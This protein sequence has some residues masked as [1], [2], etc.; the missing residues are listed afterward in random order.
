MESTT[1]VDALIHKAAEFRMPAVG[2]T[3]RGNMMAAFHFVAAGA[4]HNKGI[5]G[6]IKALE[7]KLLSGKITESSENE[8]GET[9]EAERDLKDS[10]IDS[11]TF[12][13]EDLKTAN[14]FTDC[15]K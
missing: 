14:R 7:E 11:F 9:I 5:K 6:K 1:K 8:N 15:W 12:D 4:K 2:M 10:E 13:V 3:D